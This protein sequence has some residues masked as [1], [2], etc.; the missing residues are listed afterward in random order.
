MIE[1]IVVDFETYYD[2][3]YSLSKMSTEAYI[4]DPRFQAI[5]VGI[6]MPDGTKGVI[7]G[8]H[9]EIKYKLDAIPWHEHAVVA[10]NA[11]FDA[12]ILTW[13]FGIRP[14]LW[15]DT[16]SMA[17]AIHHGKPNSLSALAERYKLKE[18]G[19][20]VANMLGRR[21]ESLTRAE[22]KQYAQYCI[23]DLDICNDLFYLMSSGFYDLDETV[24]RGKF[25]RAELELIDMIIRMFTE[26][27][28][29]LN[30]A[31]LETHLADVVR[32]KEE[33]LAK[34]AKDKDVLMSNPKFAELLM[35]M[36]VVPPTKI[37]PATGKT[38]F[39][40]AKTDPGMKALLEH[41]REEVQAVAAARMG[42]KSTLEETRTQRFIDI[43]DRG[44]LFPV[45]LKYSAART[46]RLGGSDGI[47]LQNLP[48]R[49]GK[50][51]KAA[52]EVPEGY[53]AVDCDSSNIEA[54]MLAWWATQEDLVED[55]RNK[56]DVYCKMAT[57]IY[58]REITKEDK[59]ER[60][61]GKT[62]TLG[63]GYQTGAAKL[64][65]TLKASMMPMDLP[66]EEC[67][68]IVDTYRRVNYMIPRLWKDADRAIQAMH[69]NEC[70]WLGREGVVWVEGKRG[71]KLPNG[72]YI[73][74][75]QLRQV[76]D[77][78]TGRPKWVYKDRTGT[79]DL[80]G[81]KLVENIT[82]AL[83]RIIVTYQLLKIQRRYKVA[84]TVHD[85]GL[86]VVPEADIVEGRA[87]IEQCMRW[88][89]KWAAGCPINCESEV[90][91]NYGETYAEWQN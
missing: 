34:A 16:L 36:G 31:K 30:K 76:P 11:I 40:F 91:R 39:A 78:E 18:K 71:I 85:S 90:G 19:T 25:P 37:S 27:V 53:L 44:E 68:R 70:M 80:Y 75:P 5:M 24:P 15:L 41:P 50:Q 86:I 63:C 62:V 54:R 83:A 26:P 43:A 57:A 45:P 2:K 13:V 56:V 64:Q 66:I 7:T 33:L 55:F 67:K 77:P 42:V 22:F 21:R 6:R 61:V 72:M 79:T 69:D 17:N 14:A 4:R 38:T 88:V 35:S 9:A 20:Y 3:E 48:A 46:H 65:V 89:P 12:A 51:L 87:F 1:P 28:L 8:T 59:K 47:N 58:N 49:S 82:Q 29:S 73:Q 32:K 81:G 23:D 74:Y 60:F 52:I 84:L 10:H